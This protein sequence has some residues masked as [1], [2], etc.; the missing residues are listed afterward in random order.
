MAFFEFPHTRTYDSDLGWLIKAFNEISQKLDEYLENAVITFG[1]PIT[2]DIT[3]QYPA[4]TCVIDSDGTAYLSKQ[5]VPAGVNITNTDYWLP[6]FNYDD[7]INE[8]RSQIAYN[9]QNSPTTGQAL[10]TGDLVFWKGTIYTV[11]ADMPAGTAFIDGTNIQQYTVDTKINDVAGRVSVNEA[12]I[13]QIKTELADL[14]SYIFTDVS[15]M[16]AVDLQIGDK[17][18]TMYHTNEADGGGAHYIITN[19]APTGYDVIALANGN[20]ATLVRPDVLDIAMFGAI[21]GADIYSIMVAAVTYAKANDI[22]ILMQCNDY[23]LSGTINLSVSGLEFKGIYGNKYTD[24]DR[25][26]HIILDGDYPAFTTARGTQSLVFDGLFITGP[27]VSPY[28]GKGIEFNTSNRCVVKNCLFYYLGEAVN[29]NMSVNGWSGEFFIDDN[30]VQYCGIGFHFTR[31]AGV[32]NAVTDSHIRGNI[33]AHL[34]GNF[35]NAIHLDGFIITEN[36]WYGTQGI[37]CPSTRGV[38]I[39]ENY[40]DDGTSMSINLEGNNCRASICNN[41][42]LIYGDSGDTG[43]II[44]IHGGEAVIENNCITDEANAPGLYFIQNRTAAKVRVNGNVGYDISKMFASN[45]IME[46]ICSHLTPAV[47]SCWYRFNGTDV[48]QTFNLPFTFTREPAVIGGTLFANGMQLLKASYVTDVRTSTTQLTITRT[49]AS[50]LANT[51]F[52]VLLAENT[53]DYNLS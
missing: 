14:D 41:H 20:S 37:Y 45:A 46:N 47:Y 3:E 48:T 17:A 31:S 32:T 4:L 10:A 7:N 33:V 22:N 43:A 2:W 6:I 38:V 28:V 29:C 1:D 49:S 26:W 42:F 39:S 5:P 21:G 15:E 19:D 16:V 12:D 52:S 50:A 34:T 11:L 27:S 30:L 18:I 44:W 13:V 24:S 25:H 36:H 53:P 40:I 8:L 23:H 9:A 35:L 51:I